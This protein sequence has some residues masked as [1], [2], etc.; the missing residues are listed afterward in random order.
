MMCSHLWQVL[1][2]PEGREFLPNDVVL[3][4]LQVHPLVLHSHSHCTHARVQQSQAPDHITAPKWQYLLQV[5]IAR[6]APLWQ[7][8]NYLTCHWTEAGT[9][10][11]VW[12]CRTGG[13]ES[14]S[15]CHLLIMMLRRYSSQE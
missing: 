6:S 4:F 1:V 7:R 15:V 13:V 11:S 9:T 12:R 3:Q 10:T 5:W 8:A 2:E 14:N